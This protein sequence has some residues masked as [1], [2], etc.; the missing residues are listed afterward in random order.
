ML[1]R[2][3]MFLEHW[4]H[5]LSLGGRSLLRARAFASAAVLTMALGIFSTIVMFALVQAV[6]L[7]P[8]PVRDQERLIVAWKFLP[9]GGFAHWPFQVAEI[10]AVRRESRLLE[11]VGGVS[12]N[13]ASPTIAIESGAASYV[14]SAS[15]TGHFFGT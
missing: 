15:V 10:D 7:R 1:M 13:G 6:L 11:R 2:F 9:S 8:M 14:S 4:R 12:Y 5:D 3:G